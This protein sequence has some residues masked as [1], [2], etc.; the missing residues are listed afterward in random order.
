VLNTDVLTHYKDGTQIAT[1]PHVFDTVLSNMVLGA[2]L[3][4]GA[5]VDMQIATVLIYDRALSATERQQVDTYLRDKYFPGNSFNQ[6]PIATD[7]SA[8]VATAG[9]VDVAVLSND[10]D[11]GIKTVPE[12]ALHPATVRFV[13]L[14]AVIVNVP[15]P[16]QYRAKP[17]VLSESS[18]T[19]L[20]ILNEVTPAA[21]NIA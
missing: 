7:D 17:T 21:T 16:P 10:T 14:L 4:S 5:Y 6:F 12:G 18:K 8:T 1:A 19:Q 13:P 20:S 3:S 11:D 15:V 2:E 9:S